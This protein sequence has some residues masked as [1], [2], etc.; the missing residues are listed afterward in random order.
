MIGE[1]FSFSE[2]F[3]KNEMVI[4]IIGK[5][6]GVSNAAKPASKEV[7]KRLKKSFSSNPNRANKESLKSKLLLVSSLLTSSSVM[8]NE[9]D[10][11]T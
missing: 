7:N 1:V 9:A 8:L 10:L 4:G 3:K 2:R 6:H 5:T 11:V